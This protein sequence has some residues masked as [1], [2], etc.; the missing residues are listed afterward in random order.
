MK[1]RPPHLNLIL[2]S[3]MM[4]AFALVHILLLRQKGLFIDDAVHMPA[5]YSYLITSDYRLNQE[6]PPFIKLLS[7][8]GLTVVR[9]RLPLDSPGWQQATQP[10]DPE[11]GMEK[12]EERF[13]DINADRYER[14]AFW[15]RLPMLI[16]PL[17]LA[18]AVYSLTKSVSSSSTGLLAAFLL[19]TEPNIIGNS[20]V[21][22]NDVA[23]C[24]AL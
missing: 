24:L 14:I 2:L 22:Q 13:F 11:N 18:L 23:A 10:Q 7:A 6:H 8:L 17:L 16:I 15:G 1:K 21:V 20:T 12:I 4:L 3:A 5:G 19:L 9:P